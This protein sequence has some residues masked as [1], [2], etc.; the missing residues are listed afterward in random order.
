MVKYLALAKVKRMVGFC[1]YDDEEQKIAI[2]SDFYEKIEENI[3]HYQPDCLLYK[4][5]TQGLQ[6]SQKI[7]EIKSNFPNLKVFH[8]KGISYLDS[9][10][11]AGTN[12][13][14]GLIRSSGGSYSNFYPEYHFKG[15]KLAKSERRALYAT[16]LHKPWLETDNLRLIETSSKNIEGVMN[17][18]YENLL[19]NIN[20]AD[21]TT[22]VKELDEKLT[23]MGKLSFLGSLKADEIL[24]L[25]E[26]SRKFAKILESFYNLKKNE[27]EEQSKNSNN[28]NQNVNNDSN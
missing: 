21:L 19:K 23:Q 17:I 20:M 15:Q 13:I 9:E 26:K 3:T 1:F 11:V 7:G 25:V 5:A 12:S 18:D 4:S 10:I 2:F 24:F 8:V 6:A 28:G 14:P 27:E 22:P 16:Y